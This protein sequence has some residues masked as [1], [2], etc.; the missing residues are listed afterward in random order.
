MLSD[1][2]YRVETEHFVAGFVVEGGKVI[3]CAP[4]LR[5]RLAYWMTVAVRVGD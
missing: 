5:A 1:G 3:D 2:L 4:I